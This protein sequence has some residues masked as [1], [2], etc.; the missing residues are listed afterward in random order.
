MK[1]TKQIVLIAIGLLVL[2]VFQIIEKSEEL[3]GITRIIVALA[4]AAVS[5]ALPGSINI[6][7]EENKKDKMWPRIKATGALAVFVLV[8]LFNPIG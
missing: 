3:K 7:T 5:I 4:S 6:E 8:Y 2:I 1:L